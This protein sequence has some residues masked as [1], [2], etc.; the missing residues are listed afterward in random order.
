MN[1]QLA[2]RFGLDEDESK[3]QVV[4]TEVQPLGEAAAV[5]LSPGDIITRVQDKNIKSTRGLRQALS[6]DALEHGLRLQVKG[7]SGYRTIF[8]KVSPSKK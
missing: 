1:P 3:G 6:D 7:K 8:L 4:I 5:Y 2:K